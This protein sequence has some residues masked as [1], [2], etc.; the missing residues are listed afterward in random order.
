MRMFGLLGNNKC[1]GQSCLPHD[2]IYPSKAIY[3]CVDSMQLHVC[4]HCSRRAT[5]YVDY[6]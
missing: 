6:S 4:L 1:L 5:L 3:R 2:V